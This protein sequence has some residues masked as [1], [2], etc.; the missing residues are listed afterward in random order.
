MNKLFIG[1]SIAAF[2]LQAFAKG[3]HDQ[4]ATSYT[5]AA[6]GTDGCA[7]KMLGAAQDFPPPLPGKETR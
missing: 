4:G 1:L 6:Y 7:L 5:K 3:K 2:G